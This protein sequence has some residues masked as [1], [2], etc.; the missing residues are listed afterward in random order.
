VAV[1]AALLASTA[2]HKTDSFDAE[3]AKQRGTLVDQ[4]NVVGTA[5]PFFT[6]KTLNPIWAD[7][8]KTPIVRIPKLSL[9][10]QDGRR[11]D[12]TLF[13]GKIT[14]VGFIFTSCQ[15]FCP[16]LVGGMQGVERDLS[17]R[18][19]S[20]Q[21][22]ALSVDP[23]NDTPERLHD[24]ARRHKLAVGKSWTLLTGDKQTIY[25]LARATFASQV[26]KRATAEPNFVHSEHLYV[27]D[28]QGRL[29]GVLNGTRTDLK[30]DARKLVEQLLA[31]SS[32]ERVSM[33][34]P[35]TSAQ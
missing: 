23:K 8:G 14:F 6:I 30:R 20:I 5:A 15:G 1:A 3:I 7:D 25:S 19:G 28:A 10:D 16:F 31:E 29:R 22:V 12:Q 17:G 21:F 2:C 33:A 32:K 35:T 4:V 18:S 26:F 11:R 9:I 13:T 24:Y 27:L 34:A